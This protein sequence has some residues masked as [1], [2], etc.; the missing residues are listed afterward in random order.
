M[1][2][3]VAVAGHGAFGPRGQASVR[4]GM[5][6]EHEKAGAREGDAG[7]RRRETLCLAVFTPRRWRR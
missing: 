2:R 1:A 7:A 3:D 5:E 4:P 6:V